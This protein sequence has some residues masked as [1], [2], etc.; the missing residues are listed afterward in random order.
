MPMMLDE[1]DTHLVRVF[2]FDWIRST[3]GSSKGRRRSAILSAQR[4]LRRAPVIQEH[5]GEPCIKTPTDRYL[6][7]VLPSD[8]GIYSESEWRRY[9]DE[10]LDALRA[11]NA[12]WVDSMVRRFFGGA[13]VE[14]DAD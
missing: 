6:D 4:A 11:E 2:G 7:D 3:R 8:D 14:G 5:V 1:T 13:D 12:A 9:L 10:K